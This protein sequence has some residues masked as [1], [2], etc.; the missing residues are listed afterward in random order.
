MVTWKP[1]WFS[2]SEYRNSVPER[3]RPR[4]ETHP[5]TVPTHPALGLPVKQFL[6]GKFVNE[7]TKP[8]D[9]FYGVVNHTRNYDRNGDGVV[10][11][12][13]SVDP[14]RPEDPG[15]VS[16]LNP[17]DSSGPR[18]TLFGK[19]IGRVEVVAGDGTKEIFEPGRYQ[20]ITP[21]GVSE[22]RTDRDGDGKTDWL[23]IG[24]Y[25]SS[26]APNGWP[27]IGYQPEDE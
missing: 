23:V 1:R 27:F 19:T 15:T 22:V 4:E 11:T 20:R 17:W 5:E 6:E 26:N 14:K 25:P 3:Y 7:T 16:F 12:F 18:T 24:N 2:S 9:F 10:D 13:A 8:D 21:D